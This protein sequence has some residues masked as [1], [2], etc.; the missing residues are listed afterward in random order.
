MTWT[1]APDIFLSGEKAEKNSMHGAEQPY[2][3]KNR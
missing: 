1:D 2:T 3:N